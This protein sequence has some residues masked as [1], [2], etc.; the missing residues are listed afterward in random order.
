[1][2]TVRKSHYLLVKLLLMTKEIIFN[3][4]NQ[5]CTEKGDFFENL[6]LGVD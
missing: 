1:M 3:Y 6:I 2:N 5:L 4:V